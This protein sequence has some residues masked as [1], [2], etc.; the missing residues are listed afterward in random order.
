MSSAWDVVGVRC[1]SISALQSPQ[2]PGPLS[3]PHLVGVQTHAINGCIHLEDTLTLQ[4]AGPVG[5]YGYTWYLMHATSVPPISPI[6][7]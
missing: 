6:L 5:S 3:A 2:V 1:S 4:V 7:C